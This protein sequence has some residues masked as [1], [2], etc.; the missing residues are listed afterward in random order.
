[1]GGLF[2]SGKYGFGKKRPPLIVQIPANKKGFEKSKIWEQLSHFKSVQ[3][4][5]LMIF[6]INEK[7]HLEN[8]NL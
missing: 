5:T 2:Y 4:A 6:D 8:K 7:L 3:P 1:M